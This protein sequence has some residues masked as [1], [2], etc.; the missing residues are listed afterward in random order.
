M[1]YNMFGGT[2]NHTLLYSTIKEPQFVLA[3]VRYVAYVTCHSVS[4]RK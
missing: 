3:A 4:N 1:T 2:L